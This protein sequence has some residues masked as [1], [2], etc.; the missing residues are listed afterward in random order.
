MSF[1]IHKSQ[2][3]SS[4][5]AQIDFS[6]ITD[7]DD[8][9]NLFPLSEV[10]VTDACVAKCSHRQKLEG[11]GGRNDRN[12]CWMEM[13][14]RRVMGKKSALIN[15]RKQYAR[16]GIDQGGGCDRY[17]VVVPQSSPGVG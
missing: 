16:W 4:E 3:F 7:L 9:G 13:I 6:Y 15:A 17:T 2:T 8:M 1:T 5:F 11:K 10:E 12:G 14:A